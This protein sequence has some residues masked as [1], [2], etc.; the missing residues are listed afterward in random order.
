MFTY[1]QQVLFKHCDP[2]GIVFYPRYFEMMNDC[3]EAF[4]AEMV[5][6]PFQD[7]HPTDAVPTASIATR[8]RAPSRHGDAL[9]LSLEI[10]K[11]GR[12]SL[13]LVITASCDSE[14]RFQTTATIV[15]THDGRSAP[16]PEKIRHSIQQHT[17]E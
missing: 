6:W 13:E 3:I 10:V 4:F 16:W 8:F 11:L 1:R 9:V 12:S 17:E 7:M 5:H 2:A 14:I 15:H